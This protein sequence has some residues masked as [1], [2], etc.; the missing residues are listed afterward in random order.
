MTV[1]RARCKLFKVSFEGEEVLEA[2]IQGRLPRSRALRP[3]MPRH[4]RTPI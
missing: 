2:G 4:A 3:G 1:V